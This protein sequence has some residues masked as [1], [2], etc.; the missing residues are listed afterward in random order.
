MSGVTQT[1][2][3]SKTQCLRLCVCVCDWFRW[4]H[5]GI[6]T[7][8]CCIFSQTAKSMQSGSDSMESSSRAAF[9]Q[10]VCVCVCETQ[11]VTHGDRA[12]SAITAPASPQWPLTIMLLLPWLQI[13]WFHF[14][15]IWRDGKVWDDKG[16]E[17]KDI[18]IF[19]FLCFLSQLFLL[20][21]SCYLRFSQ[22][23][24]LEGLQQ[25]VWRPKSLWVYLTLVILIHWCTL[26]FPL[27][28]SPMLIRPSTFRGEMEEL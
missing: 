19:F 23:E 26:I 17:E 3:L 5:G 4:S 11:L 12:L 14:V 22:V 13:H 6:E 18:K 9:I 1:S 21:P 20:V 28:N 2:H 16:R 27:V 15:F 24:T 8:S 10:R 25:S 7:Q